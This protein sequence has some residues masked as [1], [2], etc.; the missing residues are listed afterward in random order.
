MA[1][2]VAVVTAG[3]FACLLDNL[4]TNQLVVIIVVDLSTRGK[5]HGKNN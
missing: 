5:H 4:P 3:C 1:Y 2:E